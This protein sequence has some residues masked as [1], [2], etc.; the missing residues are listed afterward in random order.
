MKKTILHL[1][2]ACSFFLLLLAGCDLTAINE[3]PNEPTADVDYN[4]NDARLGSI[5]RTSLPTVEGD[6]E[7]R[8][9]SLMLDFYAQML[10][11]G[12]WD[13]KRYLMNEDWNQR[14]YRRV[15]SAISSL[16]IVI[17]NLSDQEDIYANAIAVAKV[18]RV[19]VA[20]NGADYFGP[21]PLAKYTKELELNPPYQSVEAL[22]TEFFKELDEAVA[23]FDQNSPNPVFN[24]AASDIVYANDAARWRKFANS[25]RLRLALHVSEVA[26]SVTSEQVAKALASGV[27]ESAADNTYISPKADGSWGQDYNYTMFQITWG[28]PLN[29]TSSFE[30]LVTGIGGVDWPDGIVNQRAILNN[31]D[32]D[33][34]VNRS[35]YKHPSNVDP[36]AP[37]MFEP[38]YLKP[39]L[40]KDNEGNLIDEKGENILDKNKK[41]IEMDYAWAGIPYGLASGDNTDK[42]IANYWPELGTLVR[43]G[44]PYKSRPYDVFLYEEV[45]FLKA[46]AFSRGFAS[47]DAKVEYEKGVRASFATWE[48]SGEVDAYLAST[49]KNLA[50]TSANFDDISGPGNTPLEKIITQKYLGLF[51]DMSME[52]WND[53]RRLNLPRMDVALSRDPLLYGSKDDNILDPMNFIKRVQYPQNETQINKAEY[54]KGVQLLGGADNVATR[55]WWDLNK[56]YCTSAN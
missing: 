39:L 9:K 28:G 34:V 22:Y 50:G 12:D 32:Q 40:S 4:L 11:G 36:R 16:N 55:I 29:M 8:I 53:K 17:R 15:Q 44:A 43:N 2:A 52:A 31:A 35:N 19:F 13:T 10:D 5:F 27:M 14:M 37:K 47:G 25:L 30:K 33:K 45:C 46:E 1:F 42:Y 7:Q 48:V 49:A 54:D 20:A 18:W 23:L 51:P 6:D 56:N 26:P 41:P 38:P 24:S 3:N 21:I